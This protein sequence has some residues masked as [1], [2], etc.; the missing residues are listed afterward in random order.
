MPRAECKKTRSNEC[1]LTGTCIYTL[2]EYAVLHFDLTYFQRMRSP[3]NWSQLM[4]CLE[5]ILRRFSVFTG[6]GLSKTKSNLFGLL[7]LEVVCYTA[8]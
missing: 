4:C 2:M 5:T 3:V 8:R 6:L 1:E 7:D